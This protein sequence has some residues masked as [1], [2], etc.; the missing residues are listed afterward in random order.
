MKKSHQEIPQ[1]DPNRRRL[2]KAGLAAPAVLGIL[3]SKPVLGAVPYTC[4]ISG[5][6]SGNESPGGPA[7]ADPCTL[8]A[9][10]DTLKTTYSG[11]SLKNKAI[12]DVFPALTTIYFHWDGSTVTSTAP[13][14]DKEA[15][16]SQVLTYDAPNGLGYAKKALVLLLNAKSLGPDS[17]PLT[18]YQAQNLYTAAATGGYFNDSNPTIHW[19]PAEVQAYIDL[20]WHQT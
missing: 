2:T 4:T 12:S 6:L 1:F 15:S 5:Q 14:P 20:L 11:P 17:Y 16:I 13:H 19:D 9:S 3:A 10:Q 18:V 7:T 8:G